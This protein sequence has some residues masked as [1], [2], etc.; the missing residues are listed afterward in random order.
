MIAPEQLRTQDGEGNSPVDLITPHG[1]MN[2]S[3][4][5]QGLKLPYLGLRPFEEADGPIFFGREDQVVALL[6]QLQAHRFVAVVG[7]S[8]SGKS[9]LVR[10][11]LL[12]ALK[13]GFLMESSEWQPVTIR[14]Q[15]D[16]YG[17]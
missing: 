6:L 13:R 7:S 9:S 17:N 12:P 15:R 3:A 4:D 8:G 14:P 10:A 16:P 1:G 2:S 5:L 11:G